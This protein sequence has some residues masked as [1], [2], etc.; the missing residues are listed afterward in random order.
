MKREIQRYATARDMTVGEFMR[1]VLWFYMDATDI[2]EEEDTFMD[3]EGA[4]QKALLDAGTFGTPLILGEVRVGGKT[5][6]S[7]WHANHVDG[8][9]RGSKRAATKD[10]KELGLSPASTDDEPLIV[11]CHRPDCVVRRHG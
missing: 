6:D 11:R 8:P 7:H 1:H 4:K 9:P 10:A 2:E 5:M 3:A